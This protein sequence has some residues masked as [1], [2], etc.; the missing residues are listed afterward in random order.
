[1]K[2]VIKMINRDMQTVCI[3]R[4][5]DIVGAYGEE[6]NLI[7]IS[8]ENIEKTLPKIADVRIKANVIFSSTVKHALYNLENFRPEIRSALELQ[9]FNVWRSAFKTLDVDQA[10]DIE[11]EVVPPIAEK[12]SEAEE[13]IEEVFAEEKPEPEAEEIVEK[14]SAEEKP[15]PE[16][17]E[18]VE[19]VSVEEEPAPE[20]E[21]IVEKVSA[22][23]EPETE[24]IVE[25]LDSV[26][27]PELMDKE[28]AIE[29]IGAIE[30]QAS[31]M[32]S[33][34]P[35]KSL[36]QADQP[37]EIFKRH[38]RDWFDFLLDYSAALIQFFMRLLTK[39][40]ISGN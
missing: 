29:H 20:A 33:H 36:D 34:S 14:V 25:E 31:E 24:E 15:E 8:K 17:E 38:K 30:H 27:I 2:G 10:Y 37:E 18:I 7:H 1:M 5:K 13:I 6:V 23:E 3:K 26:Q 22:E 11:S 16:A 40:N 28:P 19:K 4:M 32:E 9:L 35:E 21:E 39:K 12:V